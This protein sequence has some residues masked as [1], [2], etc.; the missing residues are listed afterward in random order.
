[1]RWTVCLEYAYWYEAD[2]PGG[3]PAAGE[4]AVPAAAQTGCEQGPGERVTR[5]FLFLPPRPPEPE[6]PP[7]RTDAGGTGYVRLGRRHTRYTRAA[8]TDVSAR[9][10]GREMAWEVT[11]MLATGGLFLFMFRE[12]GSP[13]PRFRLEGPPPPSAPIIRLRKPS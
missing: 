13:R 6:L 2:S 11:I 9:V 1:V 8:L 3:E 7:P 12:R 5:R 10:D 4:G